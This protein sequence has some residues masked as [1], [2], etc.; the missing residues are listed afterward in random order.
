MKRRDFMKG[1]LA[2]PVVGAVMAKSSVNDEVPK[3][4]FLE[5]S[6][7]TSRK[8]EVPHIVNTNIRVE[9]NNPRAG[10]AIVEVI[11]RERKEIKRLM[12]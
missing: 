12:R 4:R 5:G 7:S 2:L 8:V 6:G 3:D 9:M 1:L 10:E 11:G